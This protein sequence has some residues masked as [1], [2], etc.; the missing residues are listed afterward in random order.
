MMK[1]KLCSAAMLTVTM[2]GCSDNDSSNH[3]KGNISQAYQGVWQASGYGSVIQIND[4][5]YTEYKFSSSYCFTDNHENITNDKLEKLIILAEDQQSFALLE[6][7]GSQAFSAPK[8]QYDKVT[9]LPDSC[10]Q[11]LIPVA[12]EDDYVP[13]A[14]RDLSVFYQLFKEYYFSFDSKNV[15]FDALYYDVFSLVTPDTD[16]ETML[17]YMAYMTSPLEDSHIQI[18]STDGEDY[19]TSSNR[20]YIVSELIFEYASLNNLPFPIPAELITE[21]L[22]QDIEDYISAM[23]DLQWEI[24]ADYAESE[25]DINIAAD[26]L[27]RWFQ[28]EG[29]GYL[30][31]GAM[32]GFAEE[33]ENDIETASLALANL[34]SIMEQALNDLSDT[35]GLIIDIRTNTGGNDYISLAL[36]S[37]F[38]AQTNTHVYSKQAR[39][40]D[41][42]TPLI[43]VNISPRGNTLYHSPVVLLT[44]ANTVSAAEVFALSMKQLPNV[45]LVGKTTQGAF[46]DMLEFTLPS[47]IEITLSNE[48]Y[49]S[50]QHEWME[51]TGVAPDYE[52]EFF[53]QQ[54]RFKEL[55]G[56]IET[57]IG[58]ILESD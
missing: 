17:E 5:S 52:V 53:S 22:I 6:G 33:Q 19:Y 49:L 16:E 3:S 9:T 56:G 51:F 15:D 54:Q 28:N 25:E 27:I 34:D 24:V 37:R 43:D 10:I 44:S 46:S 47:G 20:P 18:I 7:Y 45:T 50:P 12:G 58:I 41:N 23:L 8:K 2:L 57:A 40:G 42:V 35:D 30:Y 21:T 38:V 39:D 26:G 1:L 14:S 48:F 36:A 55:D 31:I 29:V 32:T 11:N 13:D 4:K